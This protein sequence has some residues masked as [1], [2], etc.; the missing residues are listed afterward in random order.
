MK[1]YFK[2]KTS[3]RYREVILFSLLIAD[4]LV[5]PETSGF[6][7]NSPLP[8]KI[9]LLLSTLKARRDNYYNLR[10]EEDDEFLDNNRRGSVF[11]FGSEDEFDRRYDQNA[12]DAPEWEFCDDD[13]TA[14]LLPPAYV[15]KPVAVIH[16][17]GGT[18]F[19]SSPKLWYGSLLEE[20]VRGTNCAV[21]AT[22]IPVTLSKNPLQ[23][24]KLSRKLQRQFQLAYIDV[25][26]DEYGEDIKDVPV[27]G[28]G[29][30][31]GARLFTVLAT[32]DP[33]K[34]APAPL[35]KNYILV[36]FT[37]YGASA[38]IPGVQQLLQSRRKIDRKPLRRP[39]RKR[40]SPSRYRYDEWDEYYDEDFL[41]R[42]IDLVGEIQDTVSN[43]AEKL[44]DAVTPL[45]EELEFFPSPNE[46]WSALAKENRYS[47]PETLLI[48][49]DDD[50]VDQS[51]KLASS[52]VDLS[53]VKYA[54]LRGTHLSPLSVDP[55]D[56]SWM[57]LP[58]KATKAV[59][60]FL[61]G[62]A[63]NSSRQRQEKDDDIMRDLRQ[64]IIRY[65]T[66]VAARKK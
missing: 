41:G 35:Y 5:I 56:G 63:E 34:N 7:V 42:D 51:A 38:S 27:V 3:S 22:S 26:E 24:V 10:E 15:S 25:L 19:G 4:F 61:S 40:A 53:D 66:D 37:N 11:D 36:S 8:K 16:F 49:F 1:H 62:S 46:L 23:H 28:L 17:V 55:K 54:L 2:S 32:L 58:S 6:C 64:T 48:H 43:Q 39:Q 52:L 50:E 30:S 18:V 65:I 47:V 60:D 29:H 45:S 21:V 9:L 14:V 20:I 33:P 57:E 44:R 31:L 12:V 13:S 59:W